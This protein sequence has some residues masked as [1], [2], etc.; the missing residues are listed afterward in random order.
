MIKKALIIVLLV[1][2]L[3]SGYFYFNL[4]PQLPIANGYAAK[5]MCSCTFISQRT[6]ESI[7]SED[8]GFGP[9]AQ[10][11]TTIN[12]QNKSVTTSL[13]GMRPRTAVFRNGAGCIL[14]KDDDDY[15]IDFHVDRPILR[16]E[17]S[18]PEGTAL[19]DDSTFVNV[20]R[21]QL[22]S[23][24]YAAFDESRN[25]DSLMTRAV[26][27]IH[28][29]QLVAEEYAN[30]FGPETEILGWSMTKS[31]T[32][33]MIGILIKNGLLNLDDTNLF[34]EW[35]DDRANI[36]LRDLLQMQSGLAFSETYGA[37]SDATNMLFNAENIS[38]I[39]KS[40]QLAH[41]P[42]SH[43]SYSSG[44]TNLLARIIRDRLGNDES[45]WHLPYDSIFTRIGMTSPIMETDESGNFI[46]SSYMYATPRDW[47]RF[48]LLYLNQ[49]NW[50]GT[51]IV[52]SSF[53]E[54]VRTPASASGNIYGGQFWLNAA[55]AA[56]PDVPSDLFSCNGFQG[57]F[58]F[59]IPSYNLVVV[60]MGL[61]EEPI[62]NNN[63]FLKEIL[64]AFH[65]VEG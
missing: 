9:L 33:T 59:I 12:R 2:A 62:F 55:H 41:D 63:N 22:M 50:K 39:P 19:A 38:L 14:L 40:N 57:Q 17:L 61:S 46:G 20:D 43:W 26:V 27:V 31:I 3:F 52:D 51:Q 18:W 29:G 11:K 44:T 37:I 35:T 30:G 5:K 16:S 21:D 60:R 45:Y 64:K 6:Q 48:G 34:E 24:I 58:V 8:L 28:N 49:G 53:V 13:L 56:Y 47:A 1:I 4:W 36:T 23:A 65:P 42:G 15:N 25:M 10:T 7:Q 54:F 32:A